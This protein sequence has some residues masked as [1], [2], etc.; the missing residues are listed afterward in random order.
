MKKTYWKNILREIRST[1][2]RFFA[3]VVIVSL[4]VCMFTG[5]MVTS[6]NMLRSGD[7]FFDK[8][9]L[10]D[11]RVISTLGITQKDIEALQN[12]KGI[13]NVVGIKSVDCL[14][15][16]SKGDSLASRL[17]SFTPE[18]TVNTP[19]LLQGDFPQNAG[20]CVVL[21]TIGASS[22]QIE[23]T[24]TL[25]PENEDM[26]DTL[27][28]SEWK[29]VGIVSMPTN[30][31][32]E[33]EKVSV[34]DGQA[35]VI[36]FVPP[37]TFA[38]EIYSTAYLTVEGLK[39]FNSYSQEYQDGLEPVAEQL[40]QMGITQSELRRME[41]VE[42]AQQKLDSAKEE[43]NTQKADAEQQL[44][45][46]EKKLKEAEKQI[47]QAE[48]ELATGQT[49]WQQG[50]AQLDQKRAEVQ[51]TI[52]QKQQELEQGKQQ[53]EQ[54]KQQLEQAKQKLEQSKSQYEQALQAQQQVDTGRIQLE[55]AKQQLRD[56]EIQIA[57]LEQQLP[58][59]KQVQDTA[60]QKAE[61]AR[62]TA[63]KAEQN[64]NQL[65]QQADIQNGLAQK[66]FLD[67]IL[68]K[69]PQFSS[70]EQLLANPPAEM[71]PQEL[72]QVR[73][74]NTQYQ[75]AKR[76]VDRSQAEMVQAQTQRDLA[77]QEAKKAQL[78]YQTAQSSL[79]Q[80]KASL[81]TAK[82]TIDQKEVEL[83]QAEEQLK[84][85]QDILQQAPAMIAEGEKQ[86]QENQAKLNQAQLQIDLGETFLQQ[87]PAV[88]QGEL[89]QAQQALND[90]KAKLDQGKKDLEKGKRDLE[91]GKQEYQENKTKAEE[92]LW[93][94]EKKISDA[95]KE[96]DKIDSCQWYVLD[97][98]A[99]MPYVTFESNADK[100]S[101]ISTVFPVF[102]FLVA[103]LVALTTMT[104]MVDENRTQIG[105][106]K[107]LGYSET[108][109]TAKYLLYALVASLTGGAVGILVG[110]GAIPLLLWN[111][112][113]AMYTIPDFQLYFDWKLALLSLTVAVLCTAGATINACH[114]TLREKP[115]SLLMPK[116]PKAGKRILLERIPFVWNRMKF[117]NKVTARNLFRYKKRFFMT[118]VGIAGCTAL[119]MVGFGIQ[120]SIVNLLDTQYKNLWHYDL[121]VAVQPDL[122]PQK[123]QEIQKILQ[124]QSSVEQMLWTHQQS[125]EVIANKKT[126]TANL[127]VPQ[128][129]QEMS[130]FITLRT[131]IG[132][133]P[134]PFEKDS[135]VLTEKAAEI[136]QLKVGDTLALKLDNRNIPFTLTAIT[137]N[138]LGSGIYIAP[139]LWQ[140]VENLVDWNTILAKTSIHDPEQ[141]SQIS[142]TLLEKEGISSVVFNE[143]SSQV[144]K[145]SISN[146]NSVVLVTIVFAALLAIVVLYNLI[147]INIGERQKELATIKVLG[148]YE[149][150]VRNYIFREI[151]VLSIV[152]ALCGLALGVPLHWF[153]IKTVEMDQMMFIREIS[154]ASYFYSFALTLVFTALV[155]LIMRKSL[156]NIN[157]V[158]SLKAPE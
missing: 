108:A 41:V 51:Q 83:K 16:N 84:P 24:I 137:E 124:E 126:V 138:Y 128:N 90:A 17:Q 123:Q 89:D 114:S 19:T 57:Q 136:L 140:R 65:L 130:N 112:Y 52:A 62:Q 22:V 14:L 4:G 55:Q 132:K 75:Q 127:S 71:S 103:A 153:V 110:F 107:A 10:M 144:F 151:Y 145:D 148:F 101:S 26:T 37:E 152:G 96:I 91:K 104:R 150:E 23:D 15:T 34:G 38:T 42:Q 73:T 35:D 85:Y 3:I 20:E 87:A 77:D 135:V 134:I 46:A 66:P 105:C 116:A 122:S 94:G 53:L 139:E 155:S 25:S 88:I 49:Q 120:D 43:Y 21:D 50:T 113:S 76:Q 29:V 125:V 157:M 2:N 68:A 92:Q 7:A 56:I 154:P 40:E 33:G 6:P 119:L 79:N 149:K 82:Q 61:T 143:E 74:A 121:S 39:E 98:N 59:L 8:G 86:I 18:D 158:E 146:I 69:Y 60:L 47:Q 115:A 27:N 95:Q 54:G 133:K 80:G 11:I 111:A 93:E 109:I 1:K 81:E 118:V 45:D 63:E 12:A 67:G 58:A 48:K 131:R 129:G 28:E 32:I 31:S 156:Q 142:Q 44:A 64:H 141:Q 9:N 13:Q 78:A 106:L 36:A 99:L 5:L 117:T 72:E 147:N 102:F 70:I 100:L 97:R 30:F